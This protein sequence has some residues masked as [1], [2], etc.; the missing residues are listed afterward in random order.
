MQ[1]IS[2][3][4]HNLTQDN[5]KNKLSSLGCSPVLGHL[6]GIQRVW[7]STMEK[8][9]RL[10]RATLLDF[11]ENKKP[12]LLGLLAFQQIAFMYP[13]RTQLYP[14]CCTYLCKYKMYT[15]T[16]LN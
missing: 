10:E 8:K 15:I 12:E 13:S 16:I 4:S 6:P 9:S 2:I 3:M 5:E 11:G 7:F 1:D 14:S